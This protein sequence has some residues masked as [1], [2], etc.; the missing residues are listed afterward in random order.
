MANKLQVA[1]VVTGIDQLS[2]Q[3]KGAQK[4]ASTLS[5][6]LS[7]LGNIPFMDTL[8]GKEG[9]M[10][11]FIDGA[12]AAIAFESSMVKVRRAVDFQ[13]PE[14]FKAMS[15][16]VLDLSEKLPVSAAGIA[17]VFALGG[18]SGI[19]REELKAFAEDALKMGIAFDQTGEQSG[20]MMASWRTDFKL[21]QTEAMALADQ[22]TQLGK[23]GGVDAGKVSRIVTAAGSSGLSSGQAAAMGAVFAKGGTSE[24]AAASSMR[25]FAQTLNA[26]TLATEGQKQ[27]FKAL[28]LDAQAVSEGM[29]ADAEG[30]ISNVLTKLNAL[31][32]GKQGAMLSQLFGDQSAAPLLTDLDTLSRN[33]Q[34]VGNSQQYAGSVQEAYAATAETT[35]SRLQVMDNH[36]TRLGIAIGSALLPPVNDFLGTIG[37]LISKVSEFTEANP[38]L[39][40]SIAG[41]AAGFTLLR[42]A[43][44]AATVASAFMSAVIGNNPVG[45]IVRGIALAAGLLIANWSSVAAFFKAVWATIQAAAMMAWEGIKT[46]FSWSPLGAIIENWE[47]LKGF[48][49]ALWDVVKAVTSPF[50]NYLSGIFD[51]PPVAKVIEMWGPVA[52][53][54]GTI[55]NGV[56]ELTSTFTGFLVS[57]FDWSPLEM[58]KQ[59]W[60]PVVTWVKELWGEVKTIFEPMMALFGGGLIKGATDE[61]SQFAADQRK[62]NIGVGG[63]TGQFLMT[64]AAQAVRDEQAQ[65]NLTQGGASA[66]SLLRSP[67][68]GGAPGSLIMAG[69]LNQ[70]AAANNRTNLQ[71]ALTVQFQNAPPG[72]TVG[73]AQTNQPGFSISQRGVR[74]LSQQ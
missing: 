38:G 54:F 59:R 74:S 10:K 46:I 21:N 66:A 41:A 17:Q 29:S 60:E 15:K 39:V 69:S 2:L 47:P 11:P 25:N 12:K 68:Q 23:A 3:L 58:I 13:T 49:S 22:I 24:E 5:K 45:L 43:V 32:K 65:R 20:A 4:E 37:P 67:E 63:G 53:T 19:A 6:S 36:T 48:F 26:G 14:Q 50:M 57:V 27:A 73:E 62:A 9:L 30:T 64:N 34:L 1:M 40:R 71:G 35:A 44:V 18:K 7:A 52:E 56:T 8:T 70:Q 42:L 72:T 31:E 51:W 28:G 16:D 55:W 61:M 33:F